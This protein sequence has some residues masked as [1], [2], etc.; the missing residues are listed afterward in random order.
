MLNPLSL[1]DRR[2]RHDLVG[3]QLPL[4]DYE[5]D[6]SKL[7][8]SDLNARVAVEKLFRWWGTC[9]LLSVLTFVLLVVVPAFL[10]RTQIATT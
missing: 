3:E 4:M 6:G 7:A 10:E 1:V 2:F 9:L 8:V 5:I